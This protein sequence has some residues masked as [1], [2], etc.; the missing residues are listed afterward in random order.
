[1]SRRIQLLVTIVA[2]MLLAQPLR[3]PLDGRA[4]KLLTG[5]V[6]DE[7]GMPL[8]GARIG[9]T[10]TTRQFDVTD[11][12]GFFGMNTRAPLVV[13]RKAGFESAT[14]RPDQEGAKSTV[15]LRKLAK[16]S[17]PECSREPPCPYATGAFS[18]LCFQ[19]VSG[20][21]ATSGFD[22]D[23]SYRVYSLR[24]DSVLRALFGGKRGSIMHGAGPLW[25]SGMPVDQEVWSSVAYAESA[26]SAGERTILDSR[27]S[28]SDGKHWREI[29]A[30][31]ESAGYRNVDEA[32]AKLLDQF[33]DRVCVLPGEASR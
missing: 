23:Y 21:S 5:I 31:G 6:V 19:R 9:H 28:S 30:F 13:V 27:G 14:L 15:T 24:A 10:D 3:N 18:L 17:L 25:N 2:P 33:L 1:M 29:A 7:F 32:T 20:F 4:T 22:I 11:A 26:Y 12:R 8:E 16:P